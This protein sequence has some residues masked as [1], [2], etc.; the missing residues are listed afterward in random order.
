MSVRLYYVAADGTLGTRDQPPGEWGA[1][2]LEPKVAQ[3]VGVEWVLCES[4]KRQTAVYFA[5]LLGAE[6]SFVHRIKS[7]RG[8]EGAS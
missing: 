1:E 5:E 2:R 8:A 6:L 3:I 4:M 7:H